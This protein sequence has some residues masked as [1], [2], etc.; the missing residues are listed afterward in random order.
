MSVEDF[1]NKAYDYVIIGGGTAGLVLAA[2]LTEDPNVKVGILEAGGNGLDDLLIDGP[3]LF[4]QLWGKPEYDWMYSTVPQEGTVGRTH[5]WVRGKVLGGSS[6]VNFNMFSMASRQDLNNWAELGNE[7]WAY[8]DLLPYYRKFETYYPCGEALASKVNDKYVDATLRGTSGPIK[9]CFPGS[10]ATWLQDIWPKTV[11]NAG[12]KPSKDPRSGSAIGGFNQ[13]NTVD[14]EQNRRS[15][16]AR[17]YYEPNAKRPN[18]SLLTH[19]LVS[20]IVLEKID[21]QAKATG[22]QFIFDGST[23]TVKVNKE[24]IVCG[25]SINSPQILELSGIGSPD[26]LQKAG[27]DVIV[28]N[29]GVGDNLN[30]HTATAIM[31]GVK[32]EYPTAE[33]LKRN[34]D[35]MQQAMEAYIKHKAGPFAAPPTT[36][37]FASLE[38]VQSEFPDV[39]Q[40]IQSLVAEYAKKNPNSDPAGR[41]VLLARQLLDPK[42]AIC[43]LI[44]LASGGN[45]ENTPYPATLFPSEEPGMWLTL[46][47]C[48]TR[49][50]SRGSVHIHSSDPTVHPTIDPAYFK[51]PLDIDMM[52]R[53]ILHALTFLEVEPLKS[54]IRRDDH[55]APVHSKSGGKF[56]TT[57]EEAK[58]YV[59]RNTVTEYHPVGTCAMLPKEKGGAVNSEL[60]VYG[61]ENVRV[62]D[63]SVVPLHVQGNIVS[64]VYAIA[65]KAADIIKGVDAPKVNGSNGTNGV[66]GY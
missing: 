21:G 46:G 58:D 31:V 34:P 28:P 40:H 50:L 22:V 32:D 59:R 17:E 56:P 27:V 65:E 43:Q 41:D 54:I 10:E 63:A 37:G 4:T 6:A 12:Y 33:A 15:Y 57:L 13:L 9:I 25:G 5:G 8:D 51:H 49:S 1:K 61:T 55:G 64:L 45:I 2:R 38:K 3:N 7:G 19:A 35:I 36:T 48:S 62:V 18:L 47:A 66:N 14:P 52:A 60:K 42:E 16:A 39:E 29:D 11:L 26:V 30:D 23:H 44:A 24:V 53:S 20:K